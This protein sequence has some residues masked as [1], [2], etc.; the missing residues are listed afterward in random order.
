MFFLHQSRYGLLNFA[1][2]VILPELIG[3]FYT[4]TRYVKQVNVANELQLPST[5]INIQNEEQSVNNDANRNVFM[6]LDTNISSVDSSNVILSNHSI[7]IS[8]K[9]PLPFLMQSSSC[10]TFYGPCFYNVH[11]AN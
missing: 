2:T 3:K 6:N 9:N 10:S 5:S 1:K 4:E 11:R 7:H 8:D